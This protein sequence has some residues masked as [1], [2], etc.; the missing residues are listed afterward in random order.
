MIVLGGLCII[1]QQE[2]RMKRIKLQI[3]VSFLFILSV[4]SF[5]GEFSMITNVDHR[6]TTSLNGK[7]QIIIDPYQT[8][9]YNYRYQP[10]PNGWFKNDK[11]QKKSDLIECDFDESPALNVPGDWNTQ[12]SEL[13]YY[14][15]SV[16]YKKSF[17]YKTK[18]DKRAFLHFGAAVW[19][20]S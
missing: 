12:L 15:G 19:I 4:S 18:K 5:S 17:D 9:Y 20:R 6:D 8:G 16:W 13:F 7:W 1:L 3:L 10:N 2:T 14:E 11:H